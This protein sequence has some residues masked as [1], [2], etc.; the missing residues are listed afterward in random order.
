MPILVVT[1]IVIPSIIKGWAK[2]VKILLATFSA[3][4]M[5]EL[6]AK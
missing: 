1:E 5:L 4:D 6:P 3:S 2:V